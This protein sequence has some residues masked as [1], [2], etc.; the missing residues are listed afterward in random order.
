MPEGQG[1]IFLQT[2]G[3]SHLG[4]RQLFEKKDGVELLKVEPGM[5]CQWERI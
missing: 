5:K 2:M 3:R 1:P 4:L